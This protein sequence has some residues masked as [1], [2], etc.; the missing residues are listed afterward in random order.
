[1][2]RYNVREGW[3]VEELRR[4]REASRLDVEEI[5]NFL[6]GNEALT[7]RRREIYE[8]VLKDPAFRRD[9]RY[10]HGNEEAF[11]E[12][13]RKAV[14]IIQLSQEMDIS[15]RVDKYY[16]RTAVDEELPTSL[17]ETMFIPTIESQ[18]TEE[19]KAKWLEP[20][21]DFRIMGAYAQTE[22]GHGTYLRGLETMATYDPKTEEF[23]IHSPTQTSIK[24]WPGGLGHTST[25][26]IVP[27]RLITQG[28]DHGMHLF[29]VQL[30]SLEDHTPL[31]GINVGDIGPKF[32]YSGMDNG[33]LQLD[34][35]RIPR[36]QMLM[37]YAQVA[38]DG[39]YSKPPTDKITYGTMVQYTLGYSSNLPYTLQCCAQKG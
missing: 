31:P 28:K 34:N 10:F 8:R 6:S 35:V 36:D 5:T 22:L 15:S 38:P 32:G 1:M 13:A 24:W 37:K 2:A 14:H 19:Q 16:F 29:I 26:A 30:R 18:G 12:A 3:A 39:T 4:E 9:D 21:R 20:A 27:A 17:N 33:Y 23:V 25:H 11:D 7:A